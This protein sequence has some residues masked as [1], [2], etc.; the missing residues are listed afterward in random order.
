MTETA[1][2][3]PT[4][5]QLEADPG[6]LTFEELFLAE[7]RDLHGSLWLVTR[8]RHEAEEIAQDAFLRVWERWDRV[9]EMENP[10]GYLYATAMNAW[11][12][13]VRR[14]AVA[15]RKAIHALP[16][17]DA[18]AAIEEREAIVRALARL[19]QR[20]RAAIVLTDLLGFSSQEAAEALGVRASTVRV[21]AK[22]ARD[23]LRE[24]M[25]ER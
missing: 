19:T 15:V 1:I 24:G 9:R 7:H 20:Q 17:D 8:N 18:L 4:R 5:T 21:L 3:P 23:A 14:A 6:A 13:R 25:A 22:R 11:R 12:S 16:P 10:T 2:E